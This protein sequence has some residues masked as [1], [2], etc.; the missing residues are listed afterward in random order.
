MPL[1][2][3]LLVAAVRLGAVVVDEVWGSE[4]AVAV[5]V[6]GRVV[7]GTEVA[8]VVEGLVEG[9]LTV[10]VVVGGRTAWCEPPQEAVNTATTAIAAAEG[11][12]LRNQL[13]SWATAQHTAGFRATN[14]GLACL[15]RDPSA[16]PARIPPAWGLGGSKG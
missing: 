12:P 8:S 4:L 3:D 1:V 2:V 15:V 5:V 7:L 16:E 9:C 6:T 14:G 11:T 13:A 10:L